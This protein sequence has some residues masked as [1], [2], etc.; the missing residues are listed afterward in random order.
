M[1]IEL[2]IRSYLFKKTHSII[3]TEKNQWMF[4]KIKKGF[5]NGSRPRVL[6]EIIPPEDSSNFKD[7]LTSRQHFVRSIFEVACEHPPCS[8]NTHNLKP[9]MYYLR[10]LTFFS[11]FFSLWQSAKVCLNK[12]E[13]RKFLRSA[14]DSSEPRYN[15]HVK[16]NCKGEQHVFISFFF[17]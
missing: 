10:Q 14:T 13:G 1:L 8:Q 6:S 4:L 9:T 3:K 12:F 15:V 16:H 5:F 17:F 11:M 2:S 7:S